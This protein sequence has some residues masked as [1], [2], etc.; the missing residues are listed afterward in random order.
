VVLKTSP[1]DITINPLTPPTS[2]NTNK[3]DP[4]KPETDFQDFCLHFDSPDWLGS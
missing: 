1:G 4:N 2:Y 3:D